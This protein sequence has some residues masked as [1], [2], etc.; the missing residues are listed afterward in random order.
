MC[1]N[2]QRAKVVRRQAETAR[3]ALRPSG[4]AA[5]PQQND[6]GA[7]Q[8]HLSAKEIQERD[9]QRAIIRQQYLGQQKQKRRIAKA[10]D[11]FRYDHINMH[12]TIRLDL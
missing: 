2:K 1:R 7:R 10:S 6:G 12:V 8:E 9:K 5:D 4:S 3:A 11:K